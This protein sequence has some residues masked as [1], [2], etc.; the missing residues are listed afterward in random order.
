MS[1]PLSSTMTFFIQKILVL[2]FPTLESIVD[3]KNPT[4]QCKTIVMGYGIKFSR[5]KVSS[6]S[7]AQR[8]VQ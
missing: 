2:G 7:N 4:S 8:I 5:P 6:V 1:N 3:S